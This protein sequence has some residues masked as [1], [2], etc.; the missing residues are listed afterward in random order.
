MVPFGHGAPT[1]PGAARKRGAYA[2]GGRGVIEFGSPIPEVVEGWA[3]E[4]RRQELIDWGGAAFRL[5]RMTAVDPPDFSSGT[6]RMRT[7]TP[8]VMKASGRDD[9]GTRTTRQAWVLPAEPEFPAY[10]E[11]NLRRKAESLGLSAEVSLESITWVGPK[12]SFVVGGGA[13]PGAAMEVDLRGEPETLRAIWSWGLG[14]ANAAGFGWV[15]A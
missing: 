14:Q 8:V 10:F 11:Q 2:I 6:A 4:L 13:K 1:F 12:R 3:Q 15:I 5:T 9:Q 7:S